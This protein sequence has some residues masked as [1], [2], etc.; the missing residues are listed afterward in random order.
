[1]VPELRLGIFVA[2]NTEGGTQVSDPLP[3]QVVDYFYG[4]PPK[5]PDPPGLTREEASAYAGHYVATRRAYHGLEGMFG[6][7]SALPVTASPESYLQLPGNDGVRR[8]V[9]AAEPE[10]FRLATGT[11]D[12]PAVLLFER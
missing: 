12:G 11:D 4:P 7:F 8:L 9:P 1:I 2:T 3:G 10:T 5:P 6:R